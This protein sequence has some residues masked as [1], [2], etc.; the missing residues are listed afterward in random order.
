MNTK[1]L[2]EQIRAFNPYCE[3][4]TLS[5]IFAKMK[6]GR[7]SVINF[8]L[9][10]TGKSESSL[11]LL[12]KLDLGTEI[13]IDNNTTKKGLFEL[14]RDYPNQDIMLDECSALLRDRGTQDMLKMAI[15]GK[16]IFWIKTNSMETTEP[17]K[18]N[19]II[20]TNIPIMDSI[21]DRCFLNKTKMNKEM[22]LNFIDYLMIKKQEDKFIKYI[23]E[24]VLD[25]SKAELTDEE[26]KK[27]VSFTKLF[28]SEADAD[29][30]YSRRSIF[31][32]L[33]YFKCA[34]KFFRKLD[35]EIWN[36]I[37]QYAQLYIISGRTPSLIETILGDREMDKAELIKR[38]TAEGGYKADRQPRRLVDELIANGKLKV[39]G[40]LVMK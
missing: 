40:R 8:G 36:F 3:H 24:R 25:K 20:N 10:G 39:K 17:F 21:I 34:K 5:T 27:I 35:D 26:I 23:K 9:A 30:E 4:I 11:E 7:H 33:G 6:L 32:M 31:K 29:L 19:I 18:G 15:E 2:I 12:K 14:F 38:V 22:V 37:S 16:K 28:I 1:E 13:C